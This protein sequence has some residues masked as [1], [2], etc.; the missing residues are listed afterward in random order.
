MY[1]DL[2]ATLTP[3]VDV[4][5]G[6]FTN[7]GAD[8]RVSFPLGL[9]RALASNLVAGSNLNLYL[10]AAGPSVGFTF[11]SRNFGTTSARPSLEVTAVLTP[12][13]LISSIECTGTNQVVVRFNSVSNWT[14]ALQGANELTLEA[15]SNLFTVPA[16][17]SDDKVEYVDSVTNRQRFYRLLLSQ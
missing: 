14:Y 11:N 17:P 16:R 2:G 12:A 6:Q 5:L 7:T 4:S 8:M 10:T 9:P 13:P 3:A 1:Q 15:W